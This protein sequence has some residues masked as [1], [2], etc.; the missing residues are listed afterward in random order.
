MELNVERNTILAGIRKTLGIVEK[1]TTMPIL[2]NVLIR[3]KDNRI[4]I[5]ATDIEITLVTSYEAQ[6]IS[7]GE[8]TVSAKKIY[9]MM[10]EVPENTVHV[11]K[12]ENNLLTISCQ[13]AVYKI[14]GL[15]ADEF[16][17]VAREEDVPSF[18]VDRQCFIE[19]IAKSFFAISTDDT[20]VNLTGA[21]LEVDKEG[22]KNIIR[23]V[24]TDGH[25][26]AM[27]TSSAGEG[28]FI[29]LDKG[30]IIPRK[31]LMEMRR[32]LE[33]SSGDVFI[34]IH[35]GMFLLNGK[36]IFLKV[37]LIDAEFPDYRRVIPSE[38]GVLFRF[39][40]EKVLHA[41][42]RINVISS[43]GYGGVIFCL[44]DNCMV[45]NSNDPDVGEANDEID[46]VYDGGEIK[47][48]YNVEYLMSAIEVIDEKE[49]A[50]EIGEGTKPSVIRGEGNDRYLC[51]VMPLKL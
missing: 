30:V 42:K 28:E 26:M 51:I 33:E 29:T 12:S 41:L 40:K 45:L 39:E 18:K 17:S 13:K 36:D 23:M 2:N 1:K 6:I 35:K 25:R 27:V 50:F 24:A 22:E 15:P 48:G 16:P 37:N 46:V 44:K 19:L 11:K 47:V 10:R 20:R 31:G 43:E 21:L 49:V 4:T 14:N 3:A 38:H 34:G 9:E 7:E 5:V 8:V 32:L